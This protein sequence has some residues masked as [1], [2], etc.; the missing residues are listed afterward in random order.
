MYESSSSRIKMITMGSEFFRN[1]EINLLLNL[2]GL[3][4]LGLSIYVRRPSV[5]GDSV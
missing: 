4:L 2:L 3:A 5:S 1:S